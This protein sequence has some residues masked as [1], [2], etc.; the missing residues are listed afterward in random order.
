MNEESLEQEQ[1]LCKNNGIINIVNL[2][3]IVPDTIYLSRLHVEICSKIA[4]VGKLSTDEQQ[5]LTNILIKHSNKAKSITALITLIRAGKIKLLSIKSSYITSNILENYIDLNGVKFITDMSDDSHFIDRGHFKKIFIKLLLH[6]I[7]GLFFRKFRKSS[8]IRSWVEISQIMYGDKYDDS[9]VLIY[10]FVLNIKRHIR[11]IKHCY[12]AY[13]CVTLCGLPYSLFDYLKMIVSSKGKDFHC[14]RF[15]LNAYKKH[16]SALARIGVKTLYTSD[17]FEAGAFVM[18]KALQSRGIEVINTA[19][20]MSFGCPYVNYDT[21][22]VYNKAQQ[23]YY[24][25]KSAQV[26]YIVSPRSNTDPENCFLNSSVKRKVLILIE[27]NYERLGMQYYADLESKAV[28]MLREFGR[29]YNVD[30][31]VKIHPNRK[32]PED[33][34]QFSISGVKV[35]RHLSDLSQ[36][37]PIFVSFY[38]AAYYDFRHLGPFVFIYDG[39]VRPEEVY[40]EDGLVCAP[41]EE[42]HTEI[43]RHLN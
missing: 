14:V 39:F 11:Y 22:Y 3:N 17:E 35:V 18:V 16:A 20:G 15:E 26:N 33:L 10:P 5:L 37:A 25:L 28:D 41:L 24:S 31:Y 42:I 13:P 43:L 19:H 23:N 30:T 32:V 38:S 7:Y 8:A 27:A 12:A 40:G 4:C 29:K 6:K 36:A 34:S 9:L 2:D 21:F 1:L